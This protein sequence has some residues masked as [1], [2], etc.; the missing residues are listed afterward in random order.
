MQPTKE[1]NDLGGKTD[2]SNTEL[3]TLIWSLRCH[4]DIDRIIG[5]NADKIKKHRK[6]FGYL[7][8]STLQLLAIC[9]CK[10][11]EQSSQ[12]E[13]N[14]I[15]GIVR[16]L[17]EKSLSENQ[18]EK[19]IAF[20]RKYGNSCDLTEAKNRL[21]GTVDIFL[22]NHSQ[23]LQQLRTFRDKIGAHSEVG[24]KDKIK[25][26]PSHDEFEAL[27]E[28]A[29]DFYETATSFVSESIVP[30]C[31]EDFKIIGESFTGLLESLG[32]EVKSDFDENKCS[33]VGTHKK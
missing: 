15:P 33:G 30:I 23:S 16:S 12:Y 26:L 5:L 14:S 21:A 28:F 25:N 9:L 32:I 19:I 13:L 1:N 3:A 29:K 11:F 18:K 4:I 6:F 27:Y 10:I 2:I 24:A 7:Q 31:S 17:P 22:A 20:G 8:I